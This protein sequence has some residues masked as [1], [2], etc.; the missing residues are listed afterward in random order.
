VLDHE[1]AKQIK[2]KVAGY[3]LMAAGKLI[4]KDPGPLGTHSSLGV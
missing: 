2:L 4:G 3:D 1:P